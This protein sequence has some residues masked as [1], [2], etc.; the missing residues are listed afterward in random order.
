MKKT[1]HIYMA[2]CTV[3]VTAS[4]IAGLWLLVSVDE[5]RNSY[6]SANYRAALAKFPAQPASE[7]AIAN[8]SKV[9][10]DLIAPTLAESV[11]SLYA[12]PLYF[13][14]TFNTFESRAELRDYLVHTAENLSRS[15]VVIDDMARSGN[16]VY[17]RWTMTITAQVK[18]KTIDSESI[19]ITHLRFNSNGQVVVHQDYWDGVDGFYQHIPYVGLPIKLIREQL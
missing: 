9:Y 15:T 14:D 1:L 11:D 2:L 13:N 5:P 8:F 17:L 3:L 18:G 12:D 16:D 19:G 7:S 4:L 6:H 10:E